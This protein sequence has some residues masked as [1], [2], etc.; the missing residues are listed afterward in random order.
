MVEGWPDASSAETVASSPRKGGPPPPIEQDE[1]GG[2][3]EAIRAR[4]REAQ[5]GQLYGV[6]LVVMAILEVAASVDRLTRE[7]KER[8][9]SGAGGGA[10]RR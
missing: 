3:A 8:A 6:S 9:A 5:T 1:A 4:A 2:R 10:G 7:L